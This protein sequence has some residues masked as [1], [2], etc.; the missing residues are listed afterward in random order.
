LRSKK[1]CYWA[2]EQNMSGFRSFLDLEV[3]INFSGNIGT[4]C[5][6]WFR[7][8]HEKAKIFTSERGQ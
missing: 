6:I 8:Q 4:P 7:K 5:S 1:N 2:H 3:G